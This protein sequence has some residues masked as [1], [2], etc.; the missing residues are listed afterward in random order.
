MATVRNWKC[1]FGFHRYGP[2]IWFPPSQRR[3]C[4]DC[5]KVQGPVLFSERQRSYESW[6]DRGA[7]A[8]F[9]S[10]EKT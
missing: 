9:D 8:P 3:R 1:R 6:R 10:E 5:P 2:W 7:R 4:L